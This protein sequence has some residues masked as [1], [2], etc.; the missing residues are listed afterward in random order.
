MTPADT[1]VTSPAEAVSTTDPANGDSLI[2]SPGS[3]T[4]TFNSLDPLFSLQYVFQAGD[5]QLEQ[6][7]PDGSTTDVLD[8]SSYQNVSY[9]S[10]NQI[11]I[12]LSNTLTQGQYSIVL[13]GN[14]GTSDF[15]SN[16]AFDQSG[17]LWDP[18]V[19]QTLATFNVLPPPVAASLSTATPIG[20]IGPQTQSITGSLDLTS[21]ENV[22]IYEITLAPGHF[23]RLGVQL[24]ALQIGSSLQG[25]L[26]LFDSSGNVLAT[27]NSGTGGLITVDPYLFSGLKPGI[28]YVGVSGAG[29]LAGKPGGYDPTG[30]GTFGTSV[31]Q[32]AGGSYTLDLFADA[33]DTPTEVLRRSTSVG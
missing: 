12:P 33:A 24:Q 2:Q 15:L 4:I 11:T 28:Y 5:I 25:A 6:M 9:P 14:S 22:N 29:N 32:Q 13:V 1:P 26:S 30:S 10:Y 31:I 17:S 3:L 18:S 21:L 27:C 16:Y 7:N 19:D 20:S 23:W 8:E